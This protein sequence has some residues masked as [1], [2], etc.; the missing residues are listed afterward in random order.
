M[1]DRVLCELPL[2]KAP[3]PEMLDKWE[4]DESWVVVSAEGMRAL[5]FE[6]ANARAGEKPVGALVVFQG[7]EAREATPDERKQLQQARKAQKVQ[8]KQARAARK[9]QRAA[10]QQSA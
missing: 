5:A 1:R 6:R 9:G 2:E 8:A 4:L 10:A 7:V 3:K